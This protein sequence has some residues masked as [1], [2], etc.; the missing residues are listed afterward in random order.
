MDQMTVDVSEAPDVKAG[1]VA[2]LI[3]KSGEEE[4]TAYDYARWAGT[5]TNE[6]LSR[7][8]ARLER[9]FLP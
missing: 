3:G 4:I 6:I 7:L 5:I 2:L 9:G 1:D 8:G